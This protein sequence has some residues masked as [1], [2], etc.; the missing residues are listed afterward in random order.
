MAE[1]ERNLAIW[2]T[3]RWAYKDARL[4]AAD[5]RQHIILFGQALCRS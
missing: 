4:I 3:I 5:L 2:V 1:G